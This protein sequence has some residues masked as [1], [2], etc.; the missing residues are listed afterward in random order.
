MAK[1]KSMQCSRRDFLVFAL[2]TPGLAALSIPALSGVSVAQ[3]N[4]GGVPMKYHEVTVAHFS[5]TGSTAKLALRLGSALADK[6][7]ELDMT[8]QQLQSH[9]ISSDIM[10]M[11]VPVY[12]GR[13]PGRAVEAL[14][15]ISGKGQPCV[16]IVV[17]GNR[18]FDDALVELADIADEQGFSF[19]AA[20]GFIGQHSL[21]SEIGA[22]RPDAQDLAEID[23]FGLNILDA[24]RAGNTSAPLKIPGNRPYLAPS[25]L[26]VPILASDACT[27]CGLCAERCPVA[28]IPLDELHVTNTEKCILCMRCIRNCPVQ[29]RSLPPQVQEQF[30]T[31]LQ[32]FVKRR[33]PQ[34]FF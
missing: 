3:Q 20:G 27:S 17:Y 13:V 34:T 10:V 19:I 2:I 4:R 22:N 15:L 24:V 5:P 30:R 16:G 31:Y 9:A 23:S 12:S 29:A 32:N 1:E 18:A 6:I 8:A 21:V 28:A 7:T 11:A 26:K 33:E 14:R 25:S